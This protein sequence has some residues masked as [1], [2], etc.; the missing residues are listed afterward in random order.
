M[1]KALALKRGYTIPPK[2]YL[3]PAV[4]DK[5]ADAIKEVAKQLNYALIRKLMRA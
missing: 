5:Q 4:K 1:W 2:P 3:T